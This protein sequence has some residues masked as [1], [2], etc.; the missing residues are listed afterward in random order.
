MLALAILTL[1]AVQARATTEHRAAVA[2]DP[3]LLALT[4]AEIRHLL[5]ALAINPR[6]PDRRLHQ[7]SR[8]RR[9]HQARARDC[10]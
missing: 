6:V 5:A 2:P 3:G 8:W 9:R 7:W 1:L 4:T 10:H